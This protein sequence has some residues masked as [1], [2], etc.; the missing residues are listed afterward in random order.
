MVASSAISFLLISYYLFVCMYA[1]VCFLKICEK[2]DL[3]LNFFMDLRQRDFKLR[4]LSIQTSHQTFPQVAHHLNCLLLKSL[5][6]FLNPSAVTGPIASRCY[7]LQTLFFLHPNPLPAPP[8]PLTCC[9]ASGT[10][11]AHQSIIIFVFRQMNYPTRSQS[12]VPGDSPEPNILII[13]HM[14][15][16]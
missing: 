13:H 14:A 11:Q 2:L 8:S 9:V 3:I 7:F 10:H 4:T 1:F 16:S 12:V 5:N 15:H 6:S